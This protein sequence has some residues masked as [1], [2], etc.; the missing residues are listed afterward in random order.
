MQHKKDT[1]IY[2]KTLNKL[3]LSVLSVA[4]DLILLSVLIFFFPG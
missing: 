3:I 2:D 1:K 4:F